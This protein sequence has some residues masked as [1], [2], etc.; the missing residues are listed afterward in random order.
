M[1]LIKILKDEAW[2]EGE[3]VNETVSFEK[4][5]DKSVKIWEKHYENNQKFPLEEEC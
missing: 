4:V 2:L 3:R 1:E 5:L